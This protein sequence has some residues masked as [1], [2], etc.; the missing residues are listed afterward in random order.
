MS[1]KQKILASLNSIAMA[2]NNPNGF[3]AAM[4]RPEQRTWELTALANRSYAQG[5]I[6]Q[7][8][9]DIALWVERMEQENMELATI[10]FGSAQ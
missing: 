3:A 5:F 6:R 9:K 1:Y 4:G 7:E 8:V 10:A 2:N